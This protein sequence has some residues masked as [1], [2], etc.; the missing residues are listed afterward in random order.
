VPDEFLFSASGVCE[1][2]ECAQSDASYSRKCLHFQE[3]DFATLSR[4]G[5]GFLAF[6]Q[7]LNN[8]E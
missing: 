7:K 4:L 1:R 8:F 5:N 2:S 6:L 3:G